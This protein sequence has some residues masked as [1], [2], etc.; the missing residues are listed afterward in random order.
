MLRSYC[1]ACFFR[2][3]CLTISQLH[4]KASTAQNSLINDHDHDSTLLVPTPPLRM[5]TQA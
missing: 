1:M 4:T 5:Q 3:Q 2:D